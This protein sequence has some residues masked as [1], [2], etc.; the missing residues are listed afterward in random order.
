MSKTVFAWHARPSEEI[1][2]KK[3]FP[4]LISMTLLALGCSS[5]NS[6]GGAA[7]APPSGSAPAAEGTFSSV[8]P[9]LS[10]NC[11]GCHSEGGKAGI[12]LTSQESIMKGG[13]EGPIVT[14]GDPDKSKI[15]DALRGR[16]GA[17]QM[18]FGRTPLPEADIA[19]VE[20]WIKAGA[21]A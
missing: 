3:T 11:T 14:P 19:K 7:S 1:P 13:Q 2:L 18:P 12:N 9:I 4:F 20:A 6:G 5:S 21:K 10:A 16:N 8:Q 17:K 15:V